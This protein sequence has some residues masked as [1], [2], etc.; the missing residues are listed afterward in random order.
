MASMVRDTGMIFT[1]RVG[2]IILRL[3]TQSMLAW[4]LGP[5]LRGSYAVCIV[6]SSILC[7]LFQVGIDVASVYFVASK[8]F[9]LSEGVTYILICGGVGALLAVVTGLIA[10]Q[11]PIAF[12]EKASHLSF[13]LVLLHT[14]ITFFSIPVFHLLI[15]MHEF[16]WSAVL[17]VSMNATNLLL[18]GGLLLVFPRSVNAAL[19]GMTAAGIL[20]TLFAIFILHRKHKFRLV[21]PKLGPLL[22]MVSYGLR[23]FVGRLSNQLNYRVGT[24]IL[25]FF[26]SE[27]EIGLFSVASLIA[28][29]TLMIPDTLSIVLMPRV[30]ADEKGRHELVAQCARVVGVICAVLLAVLCLVATPFVRIV[31]SPGF[32]PMVPLIR[33]M[34][35]GLLLRSMSKL[36]E[37]YLIGMNRPGTASVA[38][39][40]GIATNLLVLCILLP[41]IGLVA[42]AMGITG[43]YLVSTVLLT[44]SF[45]RLSGMKYTEIFCPR[46]SDWNAF[47]RLLARFTRKST[48]VSAEEKDNLG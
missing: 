29:Q 30:A 31:F 23:Y 43:N 16:F 8:R 6:F 33:V 21:R 4:A 12:F 22:A 48:G 17:S 9:T 46:R 44:T 41:Q 11:M 18:I 20:N 19:V 24:V 1:S 32:L 15:A 38:I 40:A 10:I 39:G 34:A 28:M 35:I 5:G 13:R 26:A 27:S 14:V 47:G 42:A 36:F 7:L 3:A 2:V 45:H 37:P 25:A